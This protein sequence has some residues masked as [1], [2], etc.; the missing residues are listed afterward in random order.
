MFW[1]KLLLALL[2]F[3]PVQVGR[4]FW[5]DYSFIFGLRIDYLAITIYLQ[6]ILIVFLLAFWLPKNYKKLFSGKKLIFWS[7]LLFLAVINI[8]LSQNASLSFSSWLRVMEMALLGGVVA[9]E[10]V[11][12][13]RKLI[14][15]LP[16]IILFE[17]LLGVYQAIAQSSLG[18]VFWLLGERSFDIVTLGIARASWLGE[19]FLRPYG[20]FSHPN[21]LAGF[22]LVCLV[23]LLGSQPLLK[24]EKV[25][26]IGGLV[27]IIICFSR[28]V[29]LSAVLLGLGYLFYKLREFVKIKKIKA[30]FNYLAV[31]LLLLIFAF[32]F[33]KTTIENPS[34]V[35]RVKL[36]QEALEMIK[37][38]PLLGVGLGNF[39]P[40]LAVGDSSFDWLY[41][42]QP[43]HNIFLLIT[44][45]TGLMGMAAFAVL[46]YLALNKALFFPITVALLTIIF[47]GLFDHYWLTLIQNQILF[48]LVLGFSFGLRNVKIKK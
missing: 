26:V 44:A 21:S 8:V 4:H 7:L 10:P 17:L 16:G 39:I 11:K 6:D 30:G 23:L 20:T 43:V 34:V 32:L 45:E 28:V 48:T 15:V 5:P 29:W 38:K 3:L 18:G 40:V 2:L 1:E 13:Y 27:L 14:F 9:I 35:N 46:F 31:C 41:W 37:D 12:V 19:V 33:A 25:A 22:I 47:T 42:L 36:A 24:R